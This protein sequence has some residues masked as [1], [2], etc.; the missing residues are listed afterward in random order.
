MKRWTKINLIATVL[1][2]CL[3]LGVLHLYA[4]GTTA[5]TPECPPTDEVIFIPDPDNCSWYY[6]CSYGKAV[7]EQCAPGLHFN[8]ELSVCD[9]P[10]SA[11]CAD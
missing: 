2:V 9:Y 7:H 5:T 1:M 11:G 3:S 8:A 6:I 10:S 4:A